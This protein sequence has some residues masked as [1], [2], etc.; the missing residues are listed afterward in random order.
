MKEKHFE[1]VQAER[2]AKDQL[3][4][5]YELLSLRDSRLVQNC[6]D[7]SEQILKIR[8]VVG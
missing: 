5:V 3:Q 1:A 2:K 8:G 6:E 7:E 4:V